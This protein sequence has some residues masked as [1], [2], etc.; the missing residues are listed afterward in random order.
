MRE[1]DVINMWNHMQEEMSMSITASCWR[2]NEGANKGKVII[3]PCKCTNQFIHIHCLKISANLQNVLHCQ[4]CRTRYPLKIKHK[5]LL[6]CCRDSST[7]LQMLREVRVPLFKILILIFCY[8]FFV[9]IIVYVIISYDYIMKDYN[10]FIV[11]F[12]I[13]MYLCSLL[14]FIY[15]TVPI[16]INWSNRMREIYRKSTQEVKLTKQYPNVRVI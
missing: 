8:M 12:I 16:I 11:I 3:S 15:A 6:E 2:C 7:L 1:S 9:S 14:F 5:S 10:I 13:I 4:F